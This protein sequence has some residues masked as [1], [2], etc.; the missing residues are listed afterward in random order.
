[1]SKY[2]WFDG[3]EISIL[4]RK[5]ENHLELLG[6]AT[7]GDAG[8]EWVEPFGA[9]LHLSQAGE[10]WA[11]YTLRFGR[12][13]FEANR[14]AYEDIGRLVKQLMGGVRWEWAHVFTRQD[15]RG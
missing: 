2:C 3:V 15:A 1:L 7:Y 11:D 6:V 4:N 14:L 12:K 5:E 8:N 10:E 13:G 9:T